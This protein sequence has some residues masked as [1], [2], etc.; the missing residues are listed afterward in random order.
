MVQEAFLRLHRAL[1]DGTGSPRP[2]RTVAV[3][4]RLAIDH[5]RSARVRRERT[6]ARGCRSRW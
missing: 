1:A 4:T 2:R 5:L 6:S 3:T